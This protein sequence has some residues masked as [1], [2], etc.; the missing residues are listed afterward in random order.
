MGINRDGRIAKGMGNVGKLAQLLSD[1][2]KQVLSLA[3]IFYRYK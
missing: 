3:I 2:M 1:P